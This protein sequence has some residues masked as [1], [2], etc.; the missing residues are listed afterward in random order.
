MCFLT[1]A[2]RVNI[3]LTWSDSSINLHPHHVPDTVL[4]TGDTKVHETRQRHSQGGGED[5]K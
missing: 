2:F 1:G 5:V 4:D 3:Q